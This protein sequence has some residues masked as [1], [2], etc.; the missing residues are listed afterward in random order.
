MMSANNVMSPSNGAPI[1]V[2][3][4]DIV[5]GCYYLTKSKPGAKGDG[6]VFG[7]PEDVILALDSGHVETLTPIKLRVSGLFMD[8]TTERDD[9]DLLHA[10]FKKPR[11]ERRETTVGRVVFKNALPDVLPFF[12]GLLKK[13]GCSRLFSTAT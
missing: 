2:P 8:L 3:S 9:Q 12:N 11:R 10:N 6:R 5:L 1:T 13:K 7:S 4:Q